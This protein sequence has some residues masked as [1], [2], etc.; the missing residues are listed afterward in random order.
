M[1]HRNGDRCTSFSGESEKVN[2]MKKQTA[3][4]YADLANEKSSL[5][6]WADY[7]HEKG[8][9]CVKNICKRHFYTVAELKKYLGG[10]L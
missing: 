1:N 7:D 3:I 9:W 8:E 5:Y 10:R 6:Y 2:T 4:K